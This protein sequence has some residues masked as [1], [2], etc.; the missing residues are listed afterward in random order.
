M[1]SYDDVQHAAKNIRIQVNMLHGHDTCRP[2][3][4]FPGGDH[5]AGVTICRKASLA[6]QDSGPSRTAEDLALLD[7]HL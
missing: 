7:A 6:F 1:Q 5:T 4:Q 2:A 3:G